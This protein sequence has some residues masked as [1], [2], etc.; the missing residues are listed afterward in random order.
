MSE[1]LTV[2]V[3]LSDAE[4]VPRSPP[5]ASCAP[6]PAR[7]CT[8]SVVSVAGPVSAAPPVAGGDWTEKVVLI[9]VPDAT[10]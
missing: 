10:A 1:L 5:P 2:A 7:S 6:W 3:R 4:P 8:L 9:H